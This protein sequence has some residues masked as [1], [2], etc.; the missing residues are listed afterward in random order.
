MVKALTRLADME[1]QMEYEFAKLSR[2][3]LKSQI[4]RAEYEG[5]ADLPVG[6]DCLTGLL[7]ESTEDQATTDPDK[8]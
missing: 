6:M 1:A 3:Q 8:Q 7:E 4:I 2:L 5:F